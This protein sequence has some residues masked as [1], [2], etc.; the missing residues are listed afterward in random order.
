MQQEEARTPI[1][2]PLIC[3]PEPLGPGDRTEFQRGK[4]IDGVCLHVCYMWLP[5][6]K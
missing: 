4:K 2:D 3:K 5:V 1:S 6:G